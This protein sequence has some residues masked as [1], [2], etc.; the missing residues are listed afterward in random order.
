MS[1]IRLRKSRSDFASSA[2]RASSAA[3]RSA[4][5]RSR[6]ALSCRTCSS[7]R[8][9]AVISVLV[10][11]IRAAR[12]WASRATTRPWLMIQIQ[13]PSAVATRCSIRYSSV[14]PKTARRVSRMIAARSSGCATAIKRRQL[15]TVS[16][17]G[18]PRICD[19]SGSSTMRFV[20]R[21]SSQMH[22]LAAPSAISSR[23]RTA[24]SS[25]S[26][27]LT[28]VI[29]TTTPSRTWAPSARTSVNRER[30]CAHTSR[31]SV[32]RTRAVSSMAPP[33]ATASTKLLRNISRS[34]GWI[35]AN[36]RDA[37]VINS[38]ADAP[39]SASTFGLTYRHSKR[40]SRCS[41]VR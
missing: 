36:T 34:S 30:N 26:A 5:S 14:S 37:S 7:A 2:V 27:A 16:A 6:S 11:M 20:A 40:P 19:Q 22:V 15:V 33:R 4:T 9:R 35:R 24:R 18:Y 28:E 13:P 21:S 29:S 32:R 10:P 8:F 1:S 12:P 38:S 23:C 31:P 39:M 41:T 17:G 3:V 25:A